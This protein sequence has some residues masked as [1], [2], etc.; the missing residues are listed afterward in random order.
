MNLQ[1]TGIHHLTAVTAQVRRNL[2]FYTDT[3]GMR[4]VKRRST[5][6][7]SARI[8]SSTPTGWPALVAT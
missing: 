4:L 6:T 7:M 8:I 2:Q 3:L 5:R 1:L